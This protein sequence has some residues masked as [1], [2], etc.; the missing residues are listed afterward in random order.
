MGSYRSWNLAAATDII[1]V[2]AAICWMGDTP[3][4]TAPG[5]N[6]TKGQSAFSMIQPGIRNALDYPDEAAIACPK[7]MLFYNGAADGLFPVDGVKRAYAKMHKVWQSQHVDDHLVTKL[8]PGVPHE[9]NAEMQ[10]EA[11]AFLDAHLKGGE[12]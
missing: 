9:F 11:F 1:K 12:K 3:S 10:K 8:W 4:L 7:P 2:G 6:Q 5:N